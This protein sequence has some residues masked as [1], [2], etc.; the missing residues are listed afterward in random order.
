MSVGATGRT[1]A[2]TSQVRCAASYSEGARTLH[3]GWQG[4][5]SH[6]VCMV[7]RCACRTAAA[8]FCPG[9]EG[10]CYGLLESRH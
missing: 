2:N 7:R 4:S 10:F 3:S 6:P 5:L 1:A 8:E 9:A